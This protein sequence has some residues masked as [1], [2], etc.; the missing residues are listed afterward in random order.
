MKSISEKINEKGIT[1]KQV[2]KM[3]GIDVSTLS[4]IINGTQKSTSLNLINR[5]HDYLDNINTDDIETL[6][7][8]NVK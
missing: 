8:S 6:K 3:V 4:R 5:I 7:N 2:C 1:K